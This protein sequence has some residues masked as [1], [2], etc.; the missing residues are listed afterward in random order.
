MDRRIVTFGLLYISY[1][2][3]YVCR[4]N[5]GF[6]LH[7]LTSNLNL[8][9]VEVSVAGSSFEI[10]SGI[11]KIALA[12][13]VDKYSPS[14]ILAISLIMSAAINLLLCTTENI[15]LI[16]FLWG[17][18]GVLQSLG[19]PSLSNIFMNFFPSPN[20]RGR[21]YSFLSTNQNVGS[22]LPAVILPRAMKRYGWKASMWYPSLI[23]FAVGITLLL[24]LKDKPI[25]D[26]DNDTIDRRNKKSKEDVS[27]SKEQKNRN[28]EDSISIWNNIFC[29]KGLWFLAIC[30]FGISIMRTATED[31]APMLMKEMYDDTPENILVALQVGGILGSFVGAWL[32]D[33]IFKGLRAPVI[34]IFSLLSFFPLYLL[35]F[36]KPEIILFSN[37][38]NALFPSVDTLI[39]N[40]D[41]VFFWPICA[42]FLLGVTSFAPHV[43]IGLAAREWAPKQLY[44]TSG[45]FVKCFAQIGSSFAGAPIAYI[46]ESKGWQNTF[47]YLSYISCVC[48]IILIP[49]WSL[50]SYNTR[51]GER[52]EKSE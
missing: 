12:A 7:G 41:I 5:Y 40:K 23:G 16:S 52:K 31:W 42:Y 34:A 30:Y 28:I 47:S 2:A 14:K 1:V 45:G 10:T 6:W 49:V 29:N 51:M 22:S 44:S 38:L 18:N 11:S 9:K 43:L 13:L 36:T 39:N 15:Y 25:A 35:T 24:L 37:S 33:V 19:W 3:Y 27:S 48:F 21:W 17:S 26:D 4:K 46:I 8:K 20:E 32:S 50:A